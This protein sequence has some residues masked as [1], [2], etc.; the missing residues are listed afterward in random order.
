MAT[1]SMLKALF[2]GFSSLM[3]SST[4]FPVSFA[5]LQL[6][7]PKKQKKR[8]P[9]REVAATLSVLRFFSVVFLCNSNESSLAF[10]TFRTCLRLAFSLGSFVVF[11]ILFSWLF[12]SL[13]IILFGL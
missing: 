7:Q 1:V 5:T 9:K 12:H 10:C 2:V 4:F 13:V 11:Y 8:K 3:V 6:P